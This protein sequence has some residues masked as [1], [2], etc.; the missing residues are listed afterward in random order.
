MLNSALW[1]KGMSCARASGSEWCCALACGSEF[2]VFVEGGT[3]Q[4]LLSSRRQH[5]STLQGVFHL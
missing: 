5:P 2:A 3:E 4:R 1:S